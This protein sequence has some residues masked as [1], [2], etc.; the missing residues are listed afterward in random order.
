MGHQ[1]VDITRDYPPASRKGYPFLKPGAD[2][3][4]INLTA[5]RASGLPA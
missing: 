3:A 4:D 2:E 5:E 1:T